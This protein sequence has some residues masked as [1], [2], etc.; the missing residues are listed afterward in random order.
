[1]SS[2]AL[3]SYPDQDPDDPR[4]AVSAE[5]Q[6]HD[7]DESSR[8]WL[9]VGREPLLSMGSESAVQELFHERAMHVVDG[10][11]P[12]FEALM[13]TGRLPGE[14]LFDLSDLDARD[15]FMEAQRPARR[16]LLRNLIFVLDSASFREFLRDCRQFV[17]LGH[18]LDSPSPTRKVFDALSERSS[19]DLDV[20]F[21]DG[22]RSLVARALSQFDDLASC[23][24]L[25]GHVLPFS[26]FSRLQR[27][28]PSAPRLMQLLGL[29]TSRSDELPS[30]GRLLGVNDR[31]LISFSVIPD[32]VDMVPSG[33]YSEHFVRF[34]IGRLR[35]LL[36]CHDINVDPDSLL[37]AV[38]PHFDKSD[39]GKCVF[40]IETSLPSDVCDAIFPLGVRRESSA[41]RL[42]ELPLFRHSAVE[43]WLAER[44]LR[45]CASAP[46]DAPVSNE[47]QYRVVLAAKS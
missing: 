28:R 23:V 8:V 4:L 41:V 5:P 26:S 32:D 20:H 17:V 3:K 40:F 18:G 7:G 44:G 31:A 12:A 21:I 11:S 9:R 25:T 6:V 24:R 46:D 36:A 16:S 27:E 30:F 45:S 43:P 15:S 38:Q 2:P 34:L 35:D 1:M 33:F 39:E 14:F 42:F 13:K 22:S 47:I 10:H 29:A 19:G 37:S